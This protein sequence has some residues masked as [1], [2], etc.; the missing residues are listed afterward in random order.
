MSEIQAY[1]FDFNGKLEKNECGSMVFYDDHIKIVE[2][3]KAE[4]ATM[5]ASLNN[6]WNEWCHLGKV[7]D[8]LKSELAA[9]KIA[10]NELRI[11][12]D[13]MK[14]NSELVSFD[15]DGET[16]SMYA[17]KSSSETEELKAENKRLRQQLAFRGDE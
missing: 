11:A 12:L 14:S 7:N 8:K 4:M 15:N 17:T 16:S 2:K 3:L 6:S 13:T 1:D 9:T 10:H 5:K